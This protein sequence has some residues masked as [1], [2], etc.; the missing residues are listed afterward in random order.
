MASVV[1][2]IKVMLSVAVEMCDW[3]CGKNIDNAPS[4]FCPCI[5][6]YVD[7]TYC[8]VHFVD[9]ANTSIVATDIDPSL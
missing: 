6:S 5:E 7:V 8:W 1:S 2:L 4:V 3:C 9:S